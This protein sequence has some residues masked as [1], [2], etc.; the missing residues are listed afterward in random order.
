MEKIKLVLLLFLTVFI[1]EVNGQKIASFEINLAKPTN[2]LNIPVS[3]NLDTITKLPGTKLN[4]IEIT[5][6]KA[7][8]IPFQVEV[9]NDRILYWIIKIKDGRQK[10]FMFELLE[11][12]PVITEQI[13]ADKSDGDLIIHTKNKNMLS[14]YYKTVY[15]PKG[16]DTAFKRSGFIHPLWSPHGQVLTRIQPPDHY[17][18][19]GIWNPWTHVLF[20][21]DIVD[22]WNLGD[23]KGTVRF[24]NFVSIQNGPVFSE[25]EALQNH[26]VFEKNG[27]K[28]LQ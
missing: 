19:Y 13:T 15:P 9:K 16:I 12:S 17:H 27:G 28:K 2:G 4:L 22:F 11:G 1:S 14:Y 20:E 26:I 5:D 23:K 7:V 24:A 3:T 18:H 25:Y 8:Q 10:K 21:G 6:G